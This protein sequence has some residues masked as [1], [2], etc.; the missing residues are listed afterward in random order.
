MTDVAFR[1]AVEARDLDAAFAT[2]APDIVFH[3]PVTFRPFVGR[4]AVAQLLSVIVQVLEDLTYLE[5]FHTDDGSVVLHF[6]AHVGDREVEGIDLLRFD[7]DGLIRD[8]T[9]MLRP[10]SAVTAVGEAVGSRLMG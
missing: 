9:V 7:A 1:K 4:D 5:E 8:F 6:R 10:L 3:S 2:L